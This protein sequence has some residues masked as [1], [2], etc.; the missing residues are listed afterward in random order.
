MQHKKT[1]YFTLIGILLLMLTTFVKF[2]FAKSFDIKLIIFTT[3]ILFSA[4]YIT[5]SITIQTI[6][7]DDEIINTKK[8]I[9]ELFDSKTNLKLKEVET[10]FQENI[11]KQIILNIQV[12]LSNYENACIMG[13]DEVVE[14]IKN[15]S[16]DAYLLGLNLK[17]KDKI[18]I[19]KLI[20]YYDTN[21]WYNFYFCNYKSGQLVNI[22]KFKLFLS[23]VV[24]LLL[25]FF[26]AFGYD[27]WN[28]DLTFKIVFLILVIFVEIIS[29]IFSYKSL[30]KEELEQLN[31]FKKKFEENSE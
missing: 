10:K 13:F 31:K 15:K 30:K 16:F 3:I 25:S 29:S 27:N 22:P 6:N 23:Y 11:N 8:Q 19:K 14:L 28:E 21:Y 24:A 26:A 1:I 2:D 7:H 9:Y 4:I 5:T 17:R 12:I 18:K 20:K